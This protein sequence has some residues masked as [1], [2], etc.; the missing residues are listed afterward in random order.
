MKRAIY[1]L[2]LAAGITGQAHAQDNRTLTNEAQTFE[3]PDKA[4][5]RR[6][7][8]ELDKG[9]KMQLELAAIADLD[10]IGN[11]DSLVK[12]FLQD[13]APFRDSLSDELSYKRIDYVVDAADRKKVRFRQFTPYSHSYVVERGDAAA[14]RLEQDSIHLLGVLPAIGKKGG[15]HHFRISFFMN[16]FDELA[17]YADGRLQEKARII[18]EK[19]S[20]P[21]VRGK[22]GRMYLKA[23]QSISGKQTKGYF[24]APDDFLG[25]NL[26]VGI[27]NYKNYFSPSVML[28]TV[29]FFSDKSGRVIKQYEVGLIFETNFLFAND[30]TGN[31]KTYTNSFLTLICGMGP[32]REGGKGKEPYLDFV[33]SLGYLIRRDG[34][35]FEKNTFRLGTGRLSLF[36]GKTKIEPVLYFHDLFRSVTPGIR[37]MQSF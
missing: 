2:M 34:E 12:V 15:P 3:L 36:S 9:N 33:I 13:M 25:F 1:L 26:G 27:Q 5:S 19:E 35:F 23:D 30:S 4:V 10:R 14:L 7:L 6:F 29:A 18:R 11:I 21:W 22:D 31:R 32:A 24:N 16:R 17:A 8:V 20:S 28:G 37:L